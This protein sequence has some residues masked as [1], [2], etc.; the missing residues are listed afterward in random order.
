M[1]RSVDM[2]LPE[3]IE[4]FGTGVLASVGTDSVWAEMEMEFVD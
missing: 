3:W 4:R 1:R 2:R